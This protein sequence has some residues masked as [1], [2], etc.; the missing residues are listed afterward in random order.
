MKIGVFGG[1]FDP[2]HQGHIELVKT[3]IEELDLD[4][5]YVMPNGNPPHK[6]KEWDKKHRLSM[7]KLAFRNIPKVKISD[8]EINKEE[9]S[10]TYETLTDFQK[11]HPDDEIYFLMGMDNLSYFP[12]WKHPEV[13]CKLAKLVFF[14]RDGYEQTEEDVK[15]IREQFGVKPTLIAFD[16]DVSST[17]IREEL[18]K[19]TYIFHK[20]PFLVYQY[21]IRNGLYGCLAVG[22]YDSYEE[23]L[24]NY[25]EEKRFLHSI[26]VAVTAYRMA[27]RYDE[28]PKLAYFAGLLHDIAK[29][30]PLDKQLDLCKKIELHP[31]EVAYPKML[32]APAGAGFVKKKYNIKDKKL[33]SGIRYHTMG[34]KDMT[35]FDKL[36]YMAD[37]IEPCRDFD[38]VKEL[39]EA[40]FENLDEAMIK[41]I[42]TTILS[43]VEEHLKI[44][45]VLLEVRNDLLDREQKGR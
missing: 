25:I 22:E 10:Y 31:D 36:I 1:T 33:L 13:I 38:G 17:E 35:T 8:Y 14:G 21:I 39:R 44:S 3:A 24:K 41:G 16:W 6:E 27:I 23:D 20:L 11:E 42:D 40:T 19:G 37:Y 29:R 5:L 45:P 43:L 18:G 15:A 2:V 32:H 28:D 26:G 9:P 30:M 4:L 7:V 34:H 12:K